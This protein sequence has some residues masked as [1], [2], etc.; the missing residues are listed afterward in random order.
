MKKFL[1][2]ALSLLMLA[3]IAAFSA[4]GNAGQDG[5]GNTPP[6]GPDPG[7]DDP[8][9]GKDDPDPGTDDPDPGTDY[10]TLTVGD[11]TL[12]SNY[13][14][15]NIIYSFSDAQYA[16]EIEYEFESSYIRITGDT[17][18]VRSLPDGEEN[19]T[20]TAKTSHHEAEFTVT[21]S[22]AVYAQQ[23]E[24]TVQYMESSLITHG[25]KPGGVI[26]A[27][28]SFFDVRNFWSEFYTTYAGYD[29]WC[30]GI[31]ST[32]APQWEYYARRLIYPNAPAAVVLHVGTND[33]AHDQYATA[34]TAEK[35]T[36][37]FE[38]IHANLPDTH[39]YWFTI[40]PRTGI[41]LDNILAVN[42]A[43]EAYAEGKDWVTVL[44][45]CS[46]FTTGGGSGNWGMYL[47]DRIH[48]APESYS[49]FTELLEGAGLWDSLS[50]D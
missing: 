40:E 3:G 12:Y 10:G 35:I 50:A 8:D 28:D 15:A 49:V 39:I 21:V 6:V 45:S 5:G 27:G 29:A 4:C 11:T 47:S 18:S 2:L 34:Q 24:E 9:P 48:P 19:V 36:S 25:C 38:A 41:S 1:A 32:E 44:D 16:E 20:V 7:K 42:A 13:P 33:L 46:A 26:F 23:F 17:V 31:G 30:A 22:D 37:H 43:A 14:S